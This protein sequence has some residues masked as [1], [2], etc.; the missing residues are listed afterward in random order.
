M[1]Y[2]VT[3]EDKRFKIDLQR[4]GNKFIAYIDSDPLEVTVAEAGNPSHLSL[5][6]G[7]RS[8]DVTIEDEG[9][10]SV[11]GEM[12]PVKV[13]DERALQL[14]QFRRSSQ[15]AVEE[16]I[17]APMPGLVVEVEVKA[18]DRVKE[19]EGLVVIEAMKMQN[20]LKAPREGKVKKVLAKKGMPVN[21]GDTL[22]VME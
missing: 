4:E 9:L 16:S 20:E 5:I 11:D 6:A 3:V 12:F 7:N 14:A 2:I 15:R 18:G 21:G 19:G 22:L 10:V 1:P 13:E 8:Y 17:A